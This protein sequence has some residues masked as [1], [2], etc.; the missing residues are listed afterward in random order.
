ME[1]TKIKGIDWH[2]LGRSVVLNDELYL[3]SEKRFNQIFKKFLTISESKIIKVVTEKRRQEE[4][5]KLCNK[6]RKYGKLMGEIDWI[7]RD[8]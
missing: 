6:V 5:Q 2:K 8:D 4:H 7:L 1:Q 3:I